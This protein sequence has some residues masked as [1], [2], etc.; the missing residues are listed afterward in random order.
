MGYAFTFAL[1]LIGAFHVGGW[2]AAQHARWQ[3]RRRRR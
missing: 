1:S 3:E 2:A